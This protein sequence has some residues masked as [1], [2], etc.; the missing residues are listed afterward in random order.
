MAEI[1]EYDFD[2]NNLPKEMLAAIGL[3]I[4]CSAQTESIVE[5]GIAGC[6]GIDFEYGGAVTTHMPSPLRD[7]VLRSAAE[8]RIDDLDTLDALDALLDAINNAYTK[9][10]AVAHNSWCRDPDTGAIFTVKSAARTRYTMDLLPMTVDQVKSDAAFIYQAGMN[11]MSFLRVCGLLP[12]FPEQP[13]PREHKSKAA[14]KI[15]REKAPG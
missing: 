15:R 11:L 5:M 10:N 9:R 4:A 1:K 2:P 13:R 8:I 6:L 14:R 12:T 7:S 3:V